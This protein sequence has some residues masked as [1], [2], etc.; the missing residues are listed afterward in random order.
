MRIN[1]RKTGG[2]FGIQ[3]RL[4]Q[5]SFGM[6][7]SNNYPTEKWKSDYL[8]SEIYKQSHNKINEKDNGGQIWPPK[9]KTIKSQ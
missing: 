8:L 6:K 2:Q 1:I 3:F 5:T 9:I 7:D 4:V